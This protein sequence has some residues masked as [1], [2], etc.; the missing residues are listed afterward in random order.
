M[1]SNIVVLVLVH[2]LC[3]K[4]RKEVENRIV[5]QAVWWMF[6]S[7]HKLLISFG[8]FVSAQ[9]KC[10]CMSSCSWLIIGLID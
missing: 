1:L 8:L 4:R 3:G 6:N 10:A 5:G 9:E 7:F 2:R